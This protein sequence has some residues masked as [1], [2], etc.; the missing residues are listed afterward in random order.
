MAD[1]EL[2]I[3]KQVLVVQ[4][5]M[6]TMLLSMGFEGCL[7]FLNLTEPE[8]VEDLHRRYREAG[9]DCAVTN[10]FLATPH[11]LAEYGLEAHAGQ[12]NTVGVRL[13]RRA[14]FSHVLG[15]IGPC[16]LEVEPGSGWAALKAQGVTVD[17]ALVA[18]GGTPLYSEAVQQYAMAAEALAQGKPDGLLIEGFVS[19]DDAL[20]A[21]EGARGATSLPIFVNMVFPADEKASVCASVAQALVEGGAFSVGCNCMEIDASVRAI[22]A[23]RS[24]VTV[25]LMA[26][27]SAGLPVENAEGQLVWPVGPEGFS[28]ASLRLLRAGA[29]L[30]GSC[31]G[32]TPACTGAIY[33][34]VGGTELPEV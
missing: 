8:S 14:G 6:G 34:T 12:I 23:M 22:E 32:A 29:S 1:I 19:M 28:E 7:P 16:G 20:A 15:A 21:L 17:D 4:G 2:H 9:A 27:P 18:A 30:I 31:C 13:A 3:E 33:A 25:P 11:R 5:P 24:A 10:T 26:R